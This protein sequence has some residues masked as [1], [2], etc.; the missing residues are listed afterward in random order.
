MRRILKSLSVA[1][2][3]QIVSLMVSVFMS[4]FVSKVMS[5]EGYGYYQLFLF[6]STYVGITQI[7]IS[8]GLYLEHGGKKYEE[9]PM[10]DSKNLFFSTL[11]IQ[12]IILVVLFTGV[13]I[14]ENNADRKLVV[15]LDII[16]A[17]AYLWV[18]FF[19]LQLQAVNETEKYSKAII[20]GK[21]L[22]LFLFVAA[23]LIREKNHLIYSVIYTVGFGV[24]GLIVTINCRKMILYPAKFKFNFF[25]HRHTIIAGCSLLFSTL[26]SSFTIGISRVYIDHFLGIET[27]G[28]VSMALSL[29]NFFIL[30]AIQIGMVMFPNIKTFTDEKKKTFFYILNTLTVYL[31]PL[32]LLIYIPFGTVL[33]KWIPNYSE[34][35]HWLLLLVPYMVY[36]VKNQMIYNTYMKAFR[37]EKKL[38]RINIWSLFACAVLNLGIVLLS[39]N[40]EY[41]MIVINLVIIGKSLLLNK[42]VRTVMGD[43]YRHMDILEAVLCICSSFCFF[44]LT[45]H[46]L[47]LGMIVVCYVGFAYM[48]K[49]NGVFKIFKRHEG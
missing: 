20:V 17:V 13:S 49:K 33:S 31:T 24:S 8:E 41:M 16:Y 28:R 10:G 12:C 3:A 45:N 27:F 25:D 9:L 34:S 30:F 37:E 47:V 7:G 43:S 42:E 23:V 5:V 29:C 1:F 19:G 48:Q 21:V 15:F 35:I 6:Y 46:T 38:F 14:F 40:I 39:K 4:F 11:I 2:V 32:F 22:T 18:T 44:Y 26:V 36:E